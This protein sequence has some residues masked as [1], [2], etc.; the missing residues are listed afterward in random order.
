MAFDIPNYRLKNEIFDLKRTM[1]IN[2]Y[3]SKSLISRKILYNI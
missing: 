3:P 1:A 2:G